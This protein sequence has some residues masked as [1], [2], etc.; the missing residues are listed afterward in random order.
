MRHRETRSALYQKVVL[1][2][3]FVNLWLISITEPPPREGRVGHHN[4]QGNQASGGFGRGGGGGFRGNQ[5]SNMGSVAPVSQPR[6][7]MMGGGM[8]RGG[9]MGGA[10]GFQMPNMNMMNMMNGAANQFGGMPFGR[11]TGMIPQGPRGGMMGGNF[12]GGRGGGMMGGVGE[13]LLCYMFYLVLIGVDKAWA[14][15][16][17]V[18]WADA[19]A[20]MD[21]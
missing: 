17:Q 14:C 9:A 2:L 19:G 4:N 6:G 12:G 7:G 8:M 21:R 5:Q 16:P 11:G 1:P 15:Y 13:F 3:A 18:P 10:G 20:S